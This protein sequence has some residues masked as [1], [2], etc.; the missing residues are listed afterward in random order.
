MSFSL[1][2]GAAM[3]DFEYDS[4]YGKT[5]FHKFLD[6][7]VDCP[8]T[9]LFSHPKDYTAVCTTEMAA[10][11]KMSKDFAGLGIKMIGISCDSV[12]EHHGWSKDVLKFAD[13]PGDKLNFPIIADPSREIVTTLGMLDPLEVDANSGSLPA[14][15]LFIIGAKHEVKLALLY[16]ATTG[17]D[18]GEVY[19]ICRSLI[20]TRDLSLATPQGWVDGEPMICAP[21]LKTEDAKT[22]FENFHIKEL[23]SGKEYLRYVDCPKK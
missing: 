3:P 1:R 9:I 21:G 12:E 15:A 5:S 10:C 6:S 17:R 7:D 14:R 20:L 2:L 16:P 19:R 23:P 11:H 4:T 8:W 22:R 13:C 18:F